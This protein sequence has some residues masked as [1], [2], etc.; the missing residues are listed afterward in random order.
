MKKKY[1]CIIITIL[2]IFML[3]LSFKNLILKSYIL[4][5]VE[6]A[7]LSDSFTRECYLNN[8][9]Q[10][11]EYVNND[12]ALYENYDE[13]T[14][15][16]LDLEDFNVQK[17]YRID[18]T[19]NSIAEEANFEETEDKETVFNQNVSYY[20][21]IKNGKITDF[22]FSIVGETKYLIF[23]MEYKENSGYEIFFLNLNNNFID[24]CIMIFENDNNYT[25]VVRD[26]TIKNE[27]NSSKIDTYLKM[28]EGL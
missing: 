24:K 15:V 1:I 3:I 10:V 26:Y 27:D 14:I 13:D 9:L 25:S 8:D 12:I 19:N 4:N 5:K 18:V 7:S 23:Q 16:S 6:K 2:I 22:K 20:Q 11:I 17:I 21:D 28:I